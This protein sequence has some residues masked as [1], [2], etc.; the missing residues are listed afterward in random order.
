VEAH[1]HQHRID[2]CNQA[3]E[4]V[5]GVLPP[6]TIHEVDE[7]INRFD[8]WGLGIEMTIDTLIELE[9]K[10]SRSQFLAI[11]A[12]MNAMDQ[13]QSN[14]LVWLKQHCVNTSI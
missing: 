5:R 13:R 4:A 7:Y 8:E 2:L 12:A 10:I 14:R 3:L 9:L 11:E 1:P 6:E